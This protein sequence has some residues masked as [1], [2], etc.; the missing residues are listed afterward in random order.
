VRELL[1]NS[2]LPQYVKI[3]AASCLSATYLGAL[4]V[5]MFTYITRGVNAQLPTIVSLVI[6]TGLGISLNV[7][8]IHQGLE[9]QQLPLIKEGA[10]DHAGT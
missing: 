5:A 3:M 8:G 4:G 7:L 1:G 2:S 10:T 9:T 6:G